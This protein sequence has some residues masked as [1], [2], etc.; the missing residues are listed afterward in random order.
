M[1]ELRVLEAPAASFGRI[2]EEEC[3]YVWNCLRRLGVP[4]PDQEDLMHDTFMV[5]N[6]RLADF[7]TRRPVRPWLYGIAMRVASDHRK[8]ARS[9]REVLSAE[10][11]EHDQRAVR[12]DQELAAVQK[13]EL[14]MEALDTL[15]FKARAI[16]VMHDINEHTMAEAAVELGEPM[17]TLYSRL[18]VARSQFGTAVQRIR[19]SQDLS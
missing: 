12:P 14:V 1:S 9:R 15:D 3:S 18:R 11:P 10:P 4:A 16:F 5:V 8:S 2:Y 7:D 6:R 13:R 17:P 19:R